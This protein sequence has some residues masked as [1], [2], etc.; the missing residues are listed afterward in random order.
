LHEKR[1]SRH[2][3]DAAKVGIGRMATASDAAQL[4]QTLGLTT[5]LGP[6]T[7]TLCG[8]AV[9]IFTLWL[10]D[11]ITRMGYDALLAG[12]EGK[13]DFGGRIKK[14]IEL[15]LVSAS[16]GLLFLTLG[17]ALMAWAIAAKVEVR[18]SSFEVIVPAS[19]PGPPAPIPKPNNYG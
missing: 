3:G 2:D 9:K 16:P 15:R 7:A 18:G 10:G 8:T 14:D 4:G 1:T 17:V 13:F 11:R 6:I 5:Q 12:V 19:E